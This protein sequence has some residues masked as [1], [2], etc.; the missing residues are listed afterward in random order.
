MEAAWPLSRTRP[1][2]LGH[3]TARAPRDQHQSKQRSDI[4]R[5]REAVRFGHTLSSPNAQV[6]PSC[7][8]TAGG[9][10]RP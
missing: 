4:M 3:P 1:R 9:I 2:V 6:L 5:R 7:S 10:D 8:R